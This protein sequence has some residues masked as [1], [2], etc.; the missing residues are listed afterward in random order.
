[1]TTNTTVAIFTNEGQ[2]KFVEVKVTNSLL[3]T[4]STK[5][6]SKT[7]AV[8]QS[9]VHDGLNRF[10]VAGLD[11]SKFDSLSL[12]TQTIEGVNEGINIPDSLIDK[13]QFGDFTLASPGWVFCGQ[14]ADGSGSACV[15]IPCEWV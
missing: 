8:I 6:L 1:M 13:T 9:A 15:K 14:K 10:K 4:I 2:Y 5:E 7:E 12:D 11:I 3:D